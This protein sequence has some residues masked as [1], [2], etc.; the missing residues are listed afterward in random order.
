MDYPKTKKVEIVENISGVEITD[1]YRW[2]EDSDLEET[3]NWIKYQNEIVDKE[4]KDKGFNIFL[5]ELV[6]DF[7]FTN[8]TNPYPVNNRYFYKER[9]PDEDQMVLYYKDGLDGKPIKIVDPNGME[10]NNTISLDSWSNSES[11]RYV[12]YALSKSG[13][14]MGTLYIKDLNTGENLND[15]IERSR[16]FQVRWLPDDSGF[17]YERNPEVGTVSKNEE[18]IHPKVYFHKLGENSKKDKLIFGKNRPKDDM[19]SINSSVDGRYLSIAVGQKWTENDVY[20]Y[21]R[22]LEKLSLLIKDIKAKFSIVF[23]KDKLLTLTNYKADNYRILCSD[24]NNFPKS[25]DDWQEFISEKSYVLE[26]IRCTEDKI[27]VEYLVNACSKVE[28]FD[29][30]GKKIGDIPLPEYSSTAGLTTRRKEKEFFYGV[31]SF[32]FPKIV[33]RYDPVA[34]SYGEFKRIDSPINK[35]DYVVRQEWFISRDKTKIPLFIFHKKG[36]VQNGANPAILYGY[37]GFGHNQ[38][39]GFMRSWIPW[40]ERGGVFVIANIRGGGEFGKK[41]HTGGIKEKKQN[42]F[43][44][45]IAAAEYLVKEKYTTSNKL[46]ILGGRN[47]GL[48][49]SAVSLQRPDLFHAVVSRVPLTDMVRFSKFA[50][51]LRWVHEYG[52]PAKEDELKNILKWSPYHNVKGGVEYPATLFTTAEKDTRVDPLHSRKMAAILQSVNK[53]NR[54]LLFTEIQAGHGSGKPISKIVEDQAII[55]SF[56]SQELGLEI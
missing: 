17:F 39:P 11:G 5:E 13:E 6:K 14:E 35:D 1:H 27:L 42:S 20:I 46:G 12:A 51:A 49:V 15:I 41:W 10:E 44:D 33:Y 22:D 19:I 40:I 18:H 45:F 38:S 31:T 47:G 30:F 25:I 52:D 56:F 21:D 4:L 53:K 26:S 55:I 34:D 8:F 3:K 23:L 16:S 2:L 7:K 32:T 50:M 43:D 48:L 54:I 37:G 24:L 28:I 29:Y 36:L 9:Q